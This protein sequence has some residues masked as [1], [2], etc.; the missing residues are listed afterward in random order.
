MKRTLLLAV[1]CCA[2][3]AA[4]ALYADV[5]VADTF[6]NNAVLQRDREVNIWGWADAGEKVTVS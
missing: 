3:L 1:T 6:T 4:A 5:R 2:A